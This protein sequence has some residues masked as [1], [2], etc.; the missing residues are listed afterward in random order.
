MSRAY[1]ALLVNSMQRL[2]R[3][4]AD[5]ESLASISDDPITQQ[6]IE[7]DLSRW[8]AS[9]DRL[10]TL[11]ARTKW[12]N[13]IATWT[14][15]L[16]VVSFGALFIIASF[17]SPTVGVVSFLLAVDLL[18]VIACCVGYLVVIMLRGADAN[19]GDLACAICSLS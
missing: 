7:F 8:Q 9:R 15:A 4:I 5:T 19:R 11:L 16:L 14:L 13:R 1:E 18:V 17:V 3:W 10:A 2:D 6:Q 12:L